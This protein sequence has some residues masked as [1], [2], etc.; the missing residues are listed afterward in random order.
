MQIETIEQFCS[1]LGAELEDCCLFVTSSA[2]NNMPRE[3]GIYTGR[4]LS[5]CAMCQL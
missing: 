3:S 5:E 4:S 2:L 1:K